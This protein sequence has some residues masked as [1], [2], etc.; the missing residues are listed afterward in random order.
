MSADSLHQMEK[1]GK[2]PRKNMV[3]GFPGGTRS[4]EPAC[5]CWGHRRHGFD[6]WAGKLTYKKKWQPI[7][8]FLPGK[9]SRKRSLVGQSLCGHKESQMTQATQLS[10]DNK[11]ELLFSFSFF[12][13]PGSSL[14]L[15]ML[16]FLHYRHIIKKKTFTD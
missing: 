9:L 13:L 14:S 5:Q 1:R 8:V 10:T 7:P 15:L 6:P 11:Y 2:A 3:C 4:K 12:L 16:S